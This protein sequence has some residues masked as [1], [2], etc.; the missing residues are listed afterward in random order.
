MDMR[1]VDLFLAMQLVTLLLSAPLAS[2]PEL[3]DLKPEVITDDAERDSLNITIFLVLG[4]VLLIVLK[5]LG[6]SLRFLIDLAV[7]ISG[8]YLSILVSLSFLGVP[9]GLALV[10]MRRTDD[11]TLFNFSTAASVLTFSILFGAFLTPET[12]LLLLASVS[13]YDSIAVLYTKHMRFLWFRQ[14][15]DRFRRSLVFLFPHGE[16]FSIIGSGDFSLPL[17]LTV[18]TVMQDFFSGALVAFFG[19]IGFSVLQYVSNR[20]EKISDTGVP[21]IPFIA[22]FCALGF[23]FASAFRPLLP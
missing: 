4:T 20:T 19:T 10:L 18:T 3:Q 21:G 22:V 14:K 15:L 23:L 13:V 1:P 7:F 9:I 8:V 5:L 17:L 16:Q 12:C 6:L 2:Q 11:V